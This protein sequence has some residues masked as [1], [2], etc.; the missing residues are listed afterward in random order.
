MTIA[1]TTAVSSADWDD[2]LGG[3]RC[4]ALKIPGATIDAVFT[5]SGRIDKAWYEVL[6]DI[7]I[8]RWVHGS[9]APKGATFSILLTKELSTQE[10]TVRWK[11][12]AI[13]LP[14]IASILVALIPHFFADKR[15]TPPAKSAAHLE[16]WKVTGK[17][18]LGRLAFYAVDALIRPPSLDLNPDG[19][20]SGDIALET[21]EQ[22]Q[23]EPEAL[24]FRFKDRP[25]YGPVVH[26]TQA[27]DA[28]TEFGVHFDFNTHTINI[29]REI[30]VGGESMY[31]AY[32]PS[33]QAIPQ[34]VPAMAA[35]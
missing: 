28:E 27:S 8:V 25:G 11:R 22:G 23:I 7:D 30:E 33:Q 34:P 29:P 1:F 26:L 24:I 16:K 35:K 5:P 13:V 17:V 9:D 12:L 6:A 15:S 14:V 4:P 18:H 32:V 31:A 19:S 21:N 3:W 10:L 20:F 2:N